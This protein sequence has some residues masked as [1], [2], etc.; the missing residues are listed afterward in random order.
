[1]SSIESFGTASQSRSATSGAMQERL[2]SSQ[3]AAPPAAAKP[4]LQTAVRQANG[5]DTTRIMMENRP[6]ETAPQGPKLPMGTSTAA[7]LIEMRL[8]QEL[9]E[10]QEELKG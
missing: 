2:A 8:A 1:M 7:Y 5:A 4:E 3:T 10:V 6:K 9:A